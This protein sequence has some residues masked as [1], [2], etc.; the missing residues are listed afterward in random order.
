MA[1]FTGILILHVMRQHGAMI[2]RGMAGHTPL[3]SDHLSRKK[4][5]CK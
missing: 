2:H 4:R 1:E 5:A 3:S